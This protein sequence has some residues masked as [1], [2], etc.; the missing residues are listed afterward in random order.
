M[1]E[2][3]HPVYIN[4][5]PA[6]AEFIVN[7][8]NG[9]EI[10]RGQTPKIVMLD[11]GSGFFDRADY[12]VSFSKARYQNRVYR[13][14]ASGNPWYYGNILNIV[15]FFFDAATGAMW[16]LPDSLQAVLPVN[17]GWKYE[18]PALHQPV[19]KK[20]K[21]AKPLHQPVPKKPESRQFPYE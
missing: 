1:G 20:L 9:V 12:L 5:A 19:P 3:A 8:K 15:G 18:H 13:L 16:K 2:S 11:N 14:V 4:S 7:N 17:R 21:T 10:A 6:D